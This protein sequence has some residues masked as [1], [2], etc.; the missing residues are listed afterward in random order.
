MDSHMVSEQGEALAPRPDDE[1][2]DKE[3][4]FPSIEEEGDQAPVAIKKAPPSMS[5][6]DQSIATIP[7][8]HYQSALHL[9]IQR[10]LHWWRS[11]RRPFHRD[12]E[13]DSSSV[14]T[15]FPP[16]RRPLS[17]LHTPCVRLEHSLEGL[18]K[19]P[20]TVDSHTAAGLDYE[21]SL[22]HDLL[23]ETT[24]PWVATIRTSEGH[25]RD[26]GSP[27]QNIPPPQSDDQATQLLRLIPQLDQSQIQTLMTALKGKAAS[28]PS[29]RAGASRPA[30]AASSPHVMGQANNMPIRPRTIRF[31]PFES[32][33]Y[34]PRESRTRSPPYQPCYSPHHPEPRA[35]PTS[36]ASSMY[37][38]PSAAPDM[39]SEWASIK[40][41]LQ[42]L[43][44][45]VDAKV[46]WPMGPLSIRAAEV[47]Q[48]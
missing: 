39:M 24:Q 6:S 36:H 32:D 28:S 20:L 48:M 42:E 21:E 2:E 9:N 16:Q 47:P 8:S 10:R 25:H 18:R 1:Q 31:T 46:Q 23:E 43:R 5:C 12:K 29:P 17:R 13:G 4:T 37:A 30:A 40:K 38:Q 15:R 7:V 41:E 34:L 11:R 45:H 26:E 22:P 19:S 44:K 14:A 3:P 33:H 27:S 35:R